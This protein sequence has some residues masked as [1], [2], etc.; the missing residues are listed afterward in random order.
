MQ[1]VEITRE[2]CKLMG[3]FFIN[4]CIDGKKIEDLII[5]VMK[6]CLGVENATVSISLALQKSGL[7]HGLFA[8][9]IA[10]R[11]TGN[12]DIPLVSVD[13]EQVGVKE[14]ETIKIEQK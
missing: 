4:D 5:P 8:G 12:K 1:K 7:S 6:R 3:D 13:S 10:S 9:T 11:L 14:K 2:H